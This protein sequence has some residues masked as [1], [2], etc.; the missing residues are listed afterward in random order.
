MSTFLG[1]IWHDSQPWL[2]GDQ[3]DAVM[4]YP[5]GDAILKYVAQDKITS[6]EFSLALNKVLTDYARNVNE[7]AFNLLDSH[8]TQ[9]L[10]TVCGGHKQKALL[11]YTSTD[12]TNRNAMYLLWRG[13]RTRWWS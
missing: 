10:L 13:N 9:R 12:D 4:N 3:F 11:A 1:E 5:L 8:D 7:V 6:S 2:N